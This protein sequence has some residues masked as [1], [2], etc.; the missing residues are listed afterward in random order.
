MLPGIRSM[1]GLRA[2]NSVQAFAKVVHPYES[3]FWDA[4]SGIRN[5][6][7]PNGAR[8][9]FVVCIFLNLSILSF[10]KF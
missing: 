5:Q 3:T 9:T 7:L 2:R 8:L 10:Y 1:Q 4:H 6:Y